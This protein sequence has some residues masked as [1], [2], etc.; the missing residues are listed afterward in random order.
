MVGIHDPDGTKLTDSSLKCPVTTP[1]YIQSCVSTLS[2][3]R[4]HIRLHFIP[5]L[6]SRL[7]CI[8]ALIPLPLGKPLASSKQG[9]RYQRGMLPSFENNLTTS[10]PG[11]QET[12]YHLYTLPC[13]SK[14][15]RRLHGQLLFRVRLHMTMEYCK[16]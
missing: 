1:V 16:R 5:S 11:Y 10:T 2:N 9:N 4:K 15:V 6:A 7:G 13:S 14:H 12:N 3:N 8:H